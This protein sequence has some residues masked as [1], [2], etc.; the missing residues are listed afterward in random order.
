MSGIHSTGLWQI[1]VRSILL[2]HLRK[3]Y[4][5]VTMSHW[6]KC[7]SL[8]IRYGTDVPIP[9]TTLSTLLCFCSGLPSK[10]Y[11]RIMEMVLYGKHHL[12]INNKM[13]MSLHRVRHRESTNSLYG[14]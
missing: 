1:I 7:E 8:C 11:L 14:T 12:L 3:S 5:S 6:S 9:R 10:R 13:C 4:Y 2:Q